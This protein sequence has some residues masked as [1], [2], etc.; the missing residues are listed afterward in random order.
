MW[1][2]N[3]ELVTMHKEAVHLHELQQK[4]KD[5]VNT[6]KVVQSAIVAMHEWSMQYIGA[7]LKLGKKTME[8]EELEKAKVWMLI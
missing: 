1:N 6:L 2:I 8:E 5:H 7:P 4:S 3:E